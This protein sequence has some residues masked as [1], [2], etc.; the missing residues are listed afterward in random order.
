MPNGLSWSH[1]LMQVHDLN[2]MVDFYTG[3]LGFEVT[4]RGSFDDGTELVFMSQNDSD[5]HQIA[6]ASGKPAEPKPPQAN[7]FAFRV[8]SL[9]EVKD[10][11]AKLK[12]DERVQKTA[13]ITHG[14]AWS[15]YFKDPDGNGLEIFCD[16]PWHVS[17]P[18]GGPWD[19]EADNKTI[20]AST[21]EQFKDD[22]EFQPIE[23]YYSDRRDH[24]AALFHGT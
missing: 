19:P 20:L 18:Q 11:V 14:N 24:L 17:Q 16:T 2:S 10:W 3:L 7:H 9:D 1:A 12:A 4:N 22:A 5:H 6:F 13:P 15:V 21:L 23:E 8:A